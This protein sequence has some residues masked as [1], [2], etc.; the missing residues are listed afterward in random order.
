MTHPRGV[1]TTATKTREARGRDRESPSG[2]EGTSPADPLGSD[3]WLPEPGEGKSEPPARALGAAAANWGLLAMRVRCPREP[4]TCGFHRRPALAVGR[5]E[6]G[7]RR[8]EERATPACLRSKIRRHSR[9]ATPDPVWPET[10][11]WGL[12][13]RRALTCTEVLGMPLPRSPGGR[14]AGQ[15]RAAATPGSACLPLGPQGLTPGRPV[16]PLLTATKALGVP[17]T[18]LA[19]A[20]LHPDSHH[21]PPPQD[22]SPGRGRTRRKAGVCLGWWP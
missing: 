14:R 21:P 4:L 8:Q 17:A 20:G 15:P 5:G 1:P 2:P 10:Q 11:R 16:G 19:S 12:R 7:A 13:A 22:A 18:V 6:E 3:I 9:E